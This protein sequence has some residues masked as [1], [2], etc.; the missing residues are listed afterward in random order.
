VYSLTKNPAVEKAA[1]AVYDVWAK[2]RTQITGREAM[3]VILQRRAAEAAGKGDAGSLCG[4]EGTD[5]AAACEVPVGARGGADK[6]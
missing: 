6:Q 3:E 5:G 4:E 2:Y 1:N